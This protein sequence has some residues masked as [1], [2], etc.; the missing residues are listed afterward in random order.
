MK[1]AAQV[2]DSLLDETRYYRSFDKPGPL[3]VAEPCLPDNDPNNV[4]GDFQRKFK[5][6]KDVHAPR[7]GMVWNYAELLH[8]SKHTEIGK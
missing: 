5:R 8:P 4:S 2:V 6:R 3:D 7:E 1:T